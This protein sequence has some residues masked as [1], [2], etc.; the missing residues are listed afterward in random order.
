MYSNYLLVCLISCMLMSTL[1][2]RAQTIDYA[3]Q[4]S[5]IFGASCAT[6]FCH[7][8]ITAR[9]GI[10]LSSY[11][12]AMN[13]IGTGAC[14]GPPIVPGD[15]N[16]SNL[17]SKIDPN[18][19][20]CGG[21]GMPLG[22]SLITGEINTIRD[23]IDQGAAPANPADASYF[24]TYVLPIFQNSCTPGCH[25]SGSALSG[26]DLTSEA[27][28]MSSLGT[29]C[30]SPVMPGDAA[31]SPLITKID[32]DIPVCAGSDMPLIGSALGRHQITTISAWIDNL[33]PLPVQLA[34]FRVRAVEQ[35]NQL[36]WS[37]DSE[38]NNEG[39]DLQKSIDGSNWTTFA[40][41][42]GAGNSTVAQEYRY[43]D[44][45]YRAGKTYYRLKQLDFDGYYQY[46]Q[47]IAIQNFSGHQ[48][49][50]ISPNPVRDLLKIVNGQGRL[51]LYS[52]SGVKLQEWQIADPQTSLDLSRFAS[53][54]YILHLIR[55][56]GT[57]ESSRLVK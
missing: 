2:G 50:E 30:G 9:Q 57:S 41:V 25:D 43:T 1:R 15:A 33:V 20:L 19:A 21:V 31:R 27:T 13:S 35:G 47:I 12:A 44:T 40:F 24:N 45:E 53:G 42:P 46:S 34:I 4:V 56:D 14:G 55:S 8:N 54:C 23:W 5:P 38:S 36:M 48:Q 3:S 26:L 7:D 51:T 11:E 28:L 52:S 39:F 22:S 32:P 10:D 18:V 37:T 29:Q 17:V 16:A 6:V 49:V